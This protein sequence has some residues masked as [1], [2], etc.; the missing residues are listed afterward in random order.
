MI[1]GLFVDL[2]RQTRQHIST[3]NIPVRLCVIRDT[4]SSS[5][6]QNA[7]LH[8]NSRHPPHFVILFLIVIKRLTERNFEPKGLLN[9]Q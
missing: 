8:K 7:G 2:S 4:P 1:Q 9:I 6:P 5:R 3:R